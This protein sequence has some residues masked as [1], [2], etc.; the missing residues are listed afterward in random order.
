MP[1]PNVKKFMDK[2]R[3]HVSS[4]ADGIYTDDGNSTER[5]R[6]LLRITTTNL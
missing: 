2:I 6:V 3:G 5:R 4:D 1:E